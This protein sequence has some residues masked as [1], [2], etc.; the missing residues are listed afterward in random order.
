MANLRLFIKG[1][2]YLSADGTEL[3]TP[4]FTGEYAVVDCTRYLT[5]DEILSNYEEDFFNENKDNY[6]EYE[7]NKYYYAEYSPYHTQNIG[8]LLSD[9]SELQ[10]VEEE[11]NF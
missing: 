2:I 10:H 3:L 6:I 5:K 7:G 8:E 9:L 4:R 1:A 11:Y